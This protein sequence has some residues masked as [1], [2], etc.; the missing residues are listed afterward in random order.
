MNKM[1]I[2]GMSAMVA[3]FAGCAADTDEVDADGV[4]VEADG[5]G[6]GLRCGATCPDTVVIGG[7]GA[8][9][10]AAN[11]STAI[12]VGAGASVP[13]THNA[14]PGFKFTDAA[15]C[16]QHTANNQVAAA[17]LSLESIGSSRYVS[18]TNFR[19]GATA[20]SAKCTPYLSAFLKKENNAA[21]GWLAKADPTQ[22]SLSSQ[23]YYTS[24]GTV[25]QFPGTTLATAT[26]IPGSTGNLLGKFP[27]QVIEMTKSATGEIRPTLNTSDFA[28]G[29]V[30]SSE[31]YRNFPSTTTVRTWVCGVQSG[32][33]FKVG[34]LYRHPSSAT[35]YKCQL[36]TGS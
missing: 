5:S 1:R 13:H 33:I 35:Y 10:A 2:L 22:I 20:V 23:P 9:V 16:A 25:A 34:A 6:L 30:F 31:S 11:R 21:L 26:E 18:F 19:M 4:P 24:S 15:A 32:G 29:L 27:S 14:I 7:A 28:D 12:G 36:P 17:F 3:L 8:V